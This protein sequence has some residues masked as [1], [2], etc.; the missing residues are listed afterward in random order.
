MVIVEATG[1]SPEGRIS[2]GDSGL[3]NEKQVAALKPIT[4]FIKSQGAVPAIQ[5]AHAGRKA[6]TLVPWEGNGALTTA[7]GAWQSV[8]PSALAFDGNYPPPVALDEAG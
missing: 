7:Q 1:V 6:S 3:W 5:L 4:E 2:L 8:A